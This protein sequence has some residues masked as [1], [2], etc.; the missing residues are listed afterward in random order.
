[1]AK[2]HELRQAMSKAVTE[3]ELMAGKSE[4]EGFKQ[5]VHDALVEKIADLKKQLERVEAAEKIAASLATPVPGQDRLTPRAPAPPHKLFSSL[6]NFH[7]KEIDGQRVSAVDQAYTAGM[8]FKATI[9]DHA[10]S[11]E[12]CKAH[13]VPIQKAQGEGIDSAG[14][15]LVPEE[16]MAN[17]I[18]LREQFGVFRRECRVV[19]MGSDT[20][21]WPR[22]TGGLTAFFTGE[23][24]A[25]TES[26]AAWDNVNLSAK[27]LAALTRSEERRVGKECR[28][29]W[30]P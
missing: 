28:S 13:G 2:K 14:G 9:F 25:V 29:R 21:N 4:A 6:K 19:P 15:F 8:L 26:Q 7:D 1:M 22:R 30:S 16:L 27:K 23:N 17:I 20:L 18:V 24:T 12:W 11:I 10:E 3:L 5:D